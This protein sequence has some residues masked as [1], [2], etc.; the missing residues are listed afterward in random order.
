VSLKGTEKL[1]VSTEWDEVLHDW[2]VPGDGSEG[3]RRTHDR[4]VSSTAD[5]VLLEDDD[6]PED[7][8]V[9]G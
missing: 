1:Q 4:L 8:V 2:Q 9:D 5:K 3:G 6:E 7:R